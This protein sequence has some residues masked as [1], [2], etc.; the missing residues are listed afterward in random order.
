[1]SKEV[2]FTIF[3]GIY[4]EYVGGM[5]IFNYYLLKN[6][7]NK[8][9]ISILARHPFD[10]DGIKIYKSFTIRPIKLFYPLELFFVLLFHPKIKTAVISYSEASWI[11]WVLFMSAVKILKRKY[12]LVV[13][14]GKEPDKKN[15]EHLHRFF[16]S[17]SKVIAVSDD[18][19]RN[20][21]KMFHISSCVI[22]PLVPFPE[23]ETD[24][25]YYRD[26]YN[27]PQNA[28][29]FCQIGTVT[30]QKNPDTVLKALSQFTKDEMTKYNPVIVFAGHNKIGGGFISLQ[31][32]LGIADRVKML[33]F[34]PK[35]KICEIL[36]LSDIYVIASEYEGTSVSLLEAMFNSMPIV[37]SRVSGIVDTVT[38]GNSAV[39]FD[40][41]NA[42]QMKESII[43]LLS[44]P[45]TRKSLGIS[46]KE[47]YEKKYSYSRIVNDYLTI[48][49]V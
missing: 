10:Y 7:R 15:S 43:G 33:G 48:L 44:N 11:L 28:S 36:Q 32:E 6:L 40:V 19:K 5:E 12:I 38:E 16:R 27:I 20:Y 13:H 2:L 9:N 37:A 4:P 17:A 3:D 18:I 46:A 42:G 39:M 35:E 1:M 47:E 25:K 41:G 31:D 34:V 14:H 21:D 26:K 8:C 24:K 29:V 22:P 30:Q 45:E 49:S 23:A